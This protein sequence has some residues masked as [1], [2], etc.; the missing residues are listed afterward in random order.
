[1]NLYVLIAW[2]N[3]MVKIYEIKQVTMSSFANLSAES[4]R[5]SNCTV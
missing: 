3:L 2:F 4:V 5:I 1:M